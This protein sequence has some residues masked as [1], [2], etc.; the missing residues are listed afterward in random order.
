[1]GE[2]VV[3]RVLMIAYHYPPLQGSSGIQRT[4]KFSHYLPEYGWQPIVLGAHP[5]AFPVSDTTQMAEIPESV[6]VY[7]PFAM[8]AAKHC[9]IR[10]KYPLFL[11]LPDRWAS[12]WLGAIPEG[13]RIIRQYRPDV[14]WSTYPIATAHLIGLTLNRLTGIPWVADFRDPMADVDVPMTGIQRRAHEWIERNTIRH[15]TH[16]VLTTPGAL[17]IYRERYPT[18]PDRKF[19]CISNGFDEENF[20]N[21][22]KLLPVQGAVRTG[23]VVLLHSGIVYSLE[24]N[25][26]HL[27]MAI[28]A[29]MQAQKISAQT[30]KIVLRATQNDGALTQMIARYGVGGIVQLAPHISY[31]EALAEMLTTDGLLILQASNCNHQIPAKLYEYLRAGRPILALTDPIGDTARMLQEAGIRTIAPLDDVRAIQD[32]LLDFLT[33]VQQGRGESASPDYVVSCSRKAKTSQLAKLL[34]EACS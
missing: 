22:E 2:I 28:A 17:R 15:C 1:M 14:I 6:R 23:P 13:L 33:A 20:A 34:D 27:F 29:L 3:K 9:S 30:C 19:S 16:A 21:A 5:R 31:Q 4:L 24:R 10:G 12:W 32:N 25:P 11:A 26:T 7:R 8:D 18:L